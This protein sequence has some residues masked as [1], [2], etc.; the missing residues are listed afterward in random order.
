MPDIKVLFFDIGGLLLSDG[1]DRHARRRASG[2][3][4]LDW[5]DFQDRHDF[6]SP[7]FETGALTIT[8]YLR[9]TIFYRERRFSEEEFFAFMKAQSE[10]YPESLRLVRE[11]STTGRYLLA[12][13]NNESRE[14][15]DHRIK[16]FGLR[17]HFSLFLS[18]CY[19]GVKKPDEAIYKLAIDVTGYDPDQC[20]F[21]DDR[22]LNLECADLAGIRPIHF[23]SADRLRASLGELGVAA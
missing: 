9:R 3:F 8:E 6:V 17:D 10:P 4:D 5:E 7:E 18:S 19:L 13:L 11:L 2:Q 12:T 14:L 20:V 16:E 23:Q 22:K 15:N 1:W 21:V